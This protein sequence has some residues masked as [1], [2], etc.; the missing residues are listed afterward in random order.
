VSALLFIAAAALTLLLSGEIKG[1]LVFLPLWAPLAGLGAP[2]FALAA[3]SAGLARI[4]REPVREYFVARRYG[5]VRGRALPATGVWVLAGLFAAAALLL[6]VF[7]PLPLPTVPAALVLFPAVLCF[8]LWTESCRGA[9]EGHIRFKP[10]QITPLAR[11]PLSCAPAVFPFALAALAL[12]LLS[13]LFPDAAAGKP[14]QNAS[15]ISGGWKSPLELNAGHYREH[16]AFQ[17]AFPYTSLDA[18]GTPYLRYVLAGDGLIGGSDSGEPA[19]EE[20]AAIPPF[21]LDSLMDFLTNYAYTEGDPV[22]SYDGA[23]LCPII[24]LGLCVPLIFRERRMRGQLSVYI[25]KRIAA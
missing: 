23:L 15:R 1:S 4:L 18:G 22:L 16:A 13:G 14:P 11:R 9:K 20:P 2:G 25:D 3:I 5:R 17:Q 7:G 6:A 21:P 8:S 19:F 10:V 12:P 24:V